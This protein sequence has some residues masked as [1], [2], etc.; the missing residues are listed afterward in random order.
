MMSRRFKLLFGATLLIS[1]L[2]VASAGLSPVKAAG[3]ASISGVVQTGGYAAEFATVTVSDPITFIPIASTTADEN[4]AYEI[5]GL[6]YGTYIAQSVAPGNNGSFWFGSGF[7][8]PGAT[9]PASIVLDAG[10]PSNTNVSF[11]FPTGGFGGVVTGM[12][13][14][15]NNAVLT[16][17]LVSGGLSFSETAVLDEFGNF[18]LGYIP[19]GDYA[20]RIDYGPGQIFTFSE[21][22]ATG[23][24]GLSMALTVPVGQSSIS[25]IVET[26]GSQPIEFATVAVVNTANDV[27]VSTVATD[28]T[29][30]FV[31]G[32]LQH[33]AY[34]VYSVAPGNQSQLWYGGSFDDPA[35]DFPTTITLDAGTPDDNSVLIQFPTGGFGGYIAGSQ[36]PLYSAAA[37]FMQVGTTFSETSMIDQY[38]NFGLGYIPVGDYTVRVDYGFG[39]SYTFPTPYTTGNTGLSVALIV[40]DQISG[41]VQSDGGFPV[42]GATVSLVRQD[43]G[44][45]FVSTSADENGFY[46]FNDLAVGTYMAHA[47]APGN[48]SQLWYDVGFVDP[49]VTTPTALTIADQNS[50][51]VGVSFTF[52]SG[53]FGGYVSGEFDALINATF[54]AVNVSTGFTESS[55]IDEFGNFGLGYIPTGEYEIQ[56]DYEA[57]LGSGFMRTYSFPSTYNTGPTGLSVSLVVPFT[58]IQPA[59]L[60]GVVSRADGSPADG[61]RVRLLAAG[62][63]EVATT[64][65]EPDGTYVLTVSPGT[66]R[67]IASQDDEAI[68]ITAIFLAENELLAQD[69]TMIDA[70]GQVAVSGVFVDADLLPYEYGN[71]YVDCE[72]GVSVSSPVVN[73]EFT[74]VVPTGPCNFGGHASR[75]IVRPDGAYANESFEFGDFGQTPFPNTPGPH[76][77][78]TAT[79]PLTINVVD[80]NGDHV[81]ITRLSTSAYDYDSDNPAWHPTSYNSEISSDIWMGVT[82]SPGTYNLNILQL[83]NVYV[84]VNLPDGR[85][86]TQTIDTTGGPTNIQLIVAGQNPIWVVYASGVFAGDSD[87]VDD[88]TESNAPN[89]GD[90]NGDGIKD[91]FQANVS[92]FP[93]ATGSYVTFATA[94]GIVIQNVETIEAIDNPVNAPPDWKLPPE[95]YVLPE[96]LADFQLSGVTPG[97]SVDITI[98]SSNTAD[99]TGY[100][101]F[102]DGEWSVLP[103]DGGPFDN[104]VD[105]LVDRVILTLVDGGA[106]DDDGIANGVIVDPGGLVQVTP[107]L[108]EP[109]DI[110]D[111]ALSPIEPIQIGES[112]SLTVEFAGS[113]DTVFVDWGDGSDIYETDA[114]ENTLIADHTFTTPGVYAIE[115]RVLGLDGSDD[116]ASPGFV[117]VYDP[118][119]GSISANGSF[120]WPDGAAPDVPGEAKIGA[121]AK[122][123]NGL[124][125]GNFKFEF[126][127]ADGSPK[128]KFKE[129]SFDTL[130]ITSTFTYLRGTGT[131]DG[132]TTPYTFRLTAI[133]G[134]SG[135][136]A[137]DKMRLV[138]L[139]GSAILWDSQPGESAGSYPTTPIENGQVKV[140]EP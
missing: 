87:G 32:E 119:G 74:A 135:D 17:T 136:G 18:G 52:P 137:G 14:P 122:Y 72:A 63:I 57:T 99:I 111:V 133:D 15:L 7:A 12:D 108:F 13:G 4:G 113:G 118:S 130:V 80:G 125:K 97:G 85:R 43:T 56:I 58:P 46:G 65:T 109:V 110:V 73:G 24:T 70:S 91:A 49:L 55:T 60:S 96:G 88:Y 102:Q 81:E 30:A 120:A 67:L 41:I 5:A 2:V 31:V 94:P 59:T 79:T 10:T 126:T 104:D 134:Q 34:E 132:D 123:K 62:N 124:P 131:F 44:M 117:V 86:L 6:D 84:T 93:S 115:T 53:G 78:Q 19:T 77:F 103:D 89:D 47:T 100:A 33:G 76:T 139:D 105:I 36:G 69:L 82:I 37:T 54:R 64:N 66:Y 16:F 3:E 129:E 138:I 68:E 71:V 51:Y 48:E 50:R 28:A 23:P 40:P 128:L 21:T 27:V 140:R 45:G 25:G 22:Y 112:V 116:S 127:P 107:P 20:V 106:F 9:P 95:N 11:D 35:V 29:G 92:S 101:K 75:N 90:G 26:D 1:Q 121:S 61:A 83:P 38:G 8:D 39:N 114:T 42:P 98:F